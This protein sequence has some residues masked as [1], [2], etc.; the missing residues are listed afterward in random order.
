[1]LRTWPLAL[2]VC[3]GIA[4]VGIADPLDAGP[5]SPP[6]LLPNGIQRADRLW[7]KFAEADGVRLRD[8]RPTGTKGHAL[9][10]LN[11]VLDEM[12][13]KGFV[14]ERGILGVSEEQLEHLRAR[15]AAQRADIPDQNSLFLLSVPPNQDVLHW[16]ERLSGTPEIE[17]TAP[18]FV[19]APAPLPP[20]FV[21]LQ[22]YRS[23]A[24]TGLG[25]DAVRTMP[26]GT[27]DRVALID[28][29]YSW[30]L[31][32]QD[33]AAGIAVVGPTPLDPFGDTNHGTAVLGEIVSLD[34]GWGTTGLAPG[35]SIRLAAANT[36]S[37]WNVASA[38][39]V[40]AA[41]L[42]PGDVILIEQQTYGPRYTGNPPGTQLG[43]VPVEWE[44]PVYNAILTAVG[45]GIIVVEAAGNGSENLDDSAYSSSPAS[46]AP[47]LLENDSGA[48][49]VGAGSASRSR[50]NFSNYG[51]TVDLQGWGQGVATTGYGELY[52]SEGPNLYY[53][54]GFGG[55]SSASPIVASAAVLV[56]SIVRA[57]FDRSITPSELRW[58]LRQTGS[59]QTGTMSQPIGPL[60][61]VH[62][63]A[64]LALSG[65][66]APPDAFTLTQ[67]TNGAMDLTG[68]ILLQWTD[69]NGAEAY[70]ITVDDDA[71]LSSP[72]F[73]R[74]MILNS[75]FTLN[76]ALVLPGTVY[77][78]RVVASNSAGSTTG[79]PASA[80]FRTREAAPG[81]FSLVE[82]QN[83]ATVESTTPTLTWTASA[84]ADSYRVT[85]DD[86]LSF[87]SPLLL[88]T[89]ITDSFFMVPAD[90]LLDGI[91]YHWSVQAINETGASM[92]NPLFR[93]F[94]VHLRICQGDADGDGVIGFRDITSTL[95]AWGTSGPHGDANHDGSVNL[96]DVSTT[97]GLWGAPC[98]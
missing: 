12:T 94:A 52:S 65:P 2:A 69:A 98:R 77:H 41:A 6:R 53:T 11:P 85:I 36:S 83:G 21:T 16:S 14:W 89:G 13:V 57:A 15:A 23:S 59:P 50:L 78:W 31:T 64:A 33:L 34:N 96:I 35:T 82:P 92:A 70:D 51:S 47:F 95:G 97:L 93:T 24:P 88:R 22:G 30:N 38:I 75:Q 20:D 7:V 79:T 8:A 49:I 42:Q 29:E 73:E 81:Q 25:V 1:M 17:W 27:G 4:D 86:D 68:S 71:D 84:F 87:A 32:H 72:A 60:P 44:R 80:S 62:A 39:N 58:I 10:A 5:P 28:V 63:A 48:I 91:S 9:V 37:G 18:V 46:H 66:T 61:N 90:L 43:L 19:P 76:A 26:G 3:I 45:N 55:T 40:A 56:Q 54:S 74:S 67:P